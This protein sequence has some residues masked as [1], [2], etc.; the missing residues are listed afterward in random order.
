MEFNFLIFPAPKFDNQKRHNME[1]IIWIPIEEEKPKF[2]KIIKIKKNIFGKKTKLEV[3]MTESNISLYKKE[4][5][6]ESNKNKKFQ[7]KN[8]KINL[9]H[10]KKNESSE[11]EPEKDFISIKKINK[12]ILLS[13]IDLDNKMIKKNY[14]SDDYFKTSC[15]YNESFTLKKKN[16]EVSQIC[17][18]SFAN[19]INGN[20]NFS[21]NLNKMVIDN[22]KKKEKNK[23]KKKIIFNQSIQKNDENFFKKETERKKQKEFEKIHKKV[24]INEIYEEKINEIY[25]KKLNKI[26]T[27]KNISKANLFQSSQKKYFHNCSSK[28]PH[29][30]ENCKKINCAAY[31]I[32]SNCKKYEIDNYKKIIT[33][34]KTKYEKNSKINNLTLSEINKNLKIHRQ[35][36]I[37]SIPCLFI[38]CPEEKNKNKLIIFLH[39]NGEDLIGLKPFLKLLSKMLQISILCPEYAGY[40][41][42]QNAKPSEKRIKLDNLCIVKYAME[43]LKYEPDSIILIGRSLGCSFA[44][45]LANYFVFHSLILIAPFY[46]IKNLVYDKFGNFGKIIVKNSF[47]NFNLIKE[48]CLPVMFVHGTE[49]K[50]IGSKHSRELFNLSQNCFS[51]FFEVKNM[52][53]N[54]KYMKK[55]LLNPFKEFYMFLNTVGY[56]HVFLGDY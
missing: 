3:K 37:Y 38:N 35:K 47:D 52:S 43:F 4:N 23:N 12:S 32:L 51:V 45:D 36:I 54:V 24:K 14:K 13:K 16:F 53:H 2:D 42:Y 20:N 39:A 44:L 15:F 7:I 21:N 55:D 28:N 1:N 27:S 41:F 5:S 31:K 10:L 50:M 49:D 40:S 25:E 8:E 17:Q 48:L 56:N 9:F 6:E 19:K 18:N 33:Y 46:S 34:K 26:L 29:N 30:F 22:N 11:I